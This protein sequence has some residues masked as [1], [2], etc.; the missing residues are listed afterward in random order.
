MYYCTSALG[1]IEA[2]V[3]RN[4]DMQLYLVNFIIYKMYNSSPTSGSHYCLDPAHRL[5]LFPYK[6]R[7]VAQIRHDGEEGQVVSKTVPIL[8]SEVGSLWLLVAWTFAAVT[9]PKLR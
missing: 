3:V 5:A 2:V 9:F 6:K 8:E 4:V 1:A 7:H